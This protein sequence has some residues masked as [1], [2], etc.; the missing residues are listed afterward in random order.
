MSAGGNSVQMQFRGDER[1]A[2]QAAKRVLRAQEEMI[3][4]L[5]EQNREAG[6]TK[7]T[8]KENNTEWSALAKSVAGA[9]A[10]FLSVGAARQAVASTFETW[11]TNLREISEETRRASSDIISF[12]ALQQVGAKAPS[13]QRAASLAQRYGITDRPAAFNTVQALQSILGGD[14]NAGLAAAR[15]VFAATQVGVPLDVGREAEILGIARGN[16]PGLTLRRLF[17]AGQASGRDPEL[18]TKASDALKF[19]ADEV[20]GAAAIAAVAEAGRGDEA[21]TYARRA[22]IGLSRTG[23]A[24][25]FFESIGMGESTIRQRA[26]ELARRGIDTEEELVGILGMNEIRERVGVMDI[27]RGIQRGGIQNIER[28]IRGGQGE[29]GLFERQRGEIESEMPWAATAREID[30]LRAMRAD[31]QVFGAGQKGTRRTREELIRGLA[32]ERM[33]M[34]QFLGFDLID[35]EG[36]ATEL[37]T[38][39]VGLT[40]MLEA[41]GR[42]GPTGGAPAMGQEFGGPA[43]QRPQSSLEQLREEMQRLREEL[44]NNT[45]ATEEN[46]GGAAGLTGGGE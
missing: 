9:A 13:V 42:A 21:R 20:F 19:Y 7:Q 43:G 5:K 15:G 33:G 28:A 11:R 4:K 2:L 25:P 27:V 44:R 17:L 24:Q 26:F 8:A 22:A 35:A 32:L 46:T 10:A 6:R 3:R 12:A 34:R 37:A 31:E 29:V 16:A 38:F 23:S 39:F 18:I 36:R 40:S 45:A 14:L 41:V 30:M 1:D